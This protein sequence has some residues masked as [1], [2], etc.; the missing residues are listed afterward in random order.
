MLFPD[1]PLTADKYLKKK[2]LNTNLRNAQNL[3]HHLFLAVLPLPRHM[4]VFVPRRPMGG[5]PA[6]D[7][8]ND[9]TPDLRGR[10]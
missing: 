1:S 7:A 10:K 8:S 5:R 9:R 6:S 4:L 2:S 3:T